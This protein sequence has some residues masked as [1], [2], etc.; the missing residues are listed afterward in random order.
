M[1]SGEVPKGWWY[2]VRYKHQTEHVGIHGN[3]KKQQPPGAITL[4]E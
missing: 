2:Q 1:S 3:P 4:I